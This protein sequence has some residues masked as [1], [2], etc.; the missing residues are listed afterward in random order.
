M[1]HFSTSVL[2]VPEST[3]KASSTRNYFLTVDNQKIKIKCCW[4]WSRALPL[5]ALLSSFLILLLG[6]PHLLECSLKMK[7]K[8]LKKKYTH[9]TALLYFSSKPTAL[10]MCDAVLT[11]DARIEPPIQALNLRSKV[12]LLAINFKRIL[13]KYKYFYCGCAVLKAH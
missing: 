1:Y 2:Y 8:L 4:S 9:K 6:N 10:K 13:C 3:K 11:S 7:S 12:V 5:Y